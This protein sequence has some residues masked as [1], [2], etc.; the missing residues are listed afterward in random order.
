MAI[1]NFV[2]YKVSTGKILRTGSCDLAN[3]PSQLQSGEDYLL[4]TGS[5]NDSTHYVAYPGTTSAVLTSKGSFSIQGPLTTK[6]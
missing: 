4:S 2:A 3:I 1:V 5:E 6:V